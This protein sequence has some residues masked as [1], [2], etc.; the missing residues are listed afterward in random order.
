MINHLPH[1]YSAILSEI[2]KTSTASLYWTLREQCG[3]EVAG[4]SRMLEAVSAP[5][6][7]S[8]PTG[9]AEPVS[10]RLHSISHE[11][12]HRQAHRLLSGLVAH[13]PATNR[14]RDGAHGRHWPAASSVT[15]LSEYP[16]MEGSQEPLGL[17]EI[18]GVV[19]LLRRVA[20]LLHEA[21]I[22]PWRYQTWIFPHDLDFATRLPASS[23]S[24]SACRPAPARRR[25]VHDLGGR[26]VPTAHGPSRRHPE[27]RHPPGRLR[28]HGTLAYLGACER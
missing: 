21:A 6:R 20:P 23:I 10:P 14:R 4:S 19:D 2:R 12:R 7:S 15:P 1:E 11:G 25:R 17:D 13:R 27:A 8:T 9:S 24:T 5:P 28:R 16:M 3:V 26:Q 22:R 18:L